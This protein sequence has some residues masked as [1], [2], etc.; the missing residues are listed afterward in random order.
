[1]EITDRAGTTHDRH[2]TRVGNA[3]VSLGNL[4]WSD[5]AFLEARRRADCHVTGSAS[6]K[7]D[8]HLILTAP[9]RSTSVIDGLPRSSF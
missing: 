7:L 9:D 5:T 2:H 1:M 6:L 3:G 4:S 8:R